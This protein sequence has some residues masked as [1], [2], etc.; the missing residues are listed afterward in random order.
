MSSHVT[1]E[2]RF[3]ARMKAAWPSIQRRQSVEVLPQKRG[4][5][6]P[7]LCLTDADHALGSSVVKATCLRHDVPA[8]LVM[9]D[10]RRSNVV[11]CRSEAYAILRDNGWSLPRIALF[12]GKDHTSVLWCLRKFQSA[13]DKVAAKSGPVTQAAID[14][15]WKARGY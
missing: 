14:A 8:S 4:P 15:W 11:A 9:A 5:G 12:F 1:I 6:R 13:E 2:D 10:C 7:A 3:N